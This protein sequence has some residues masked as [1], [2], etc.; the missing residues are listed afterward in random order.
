MQVE[1]QDTYLPAVR[2]KI[3]TF[4]QTPYPVSGQQPAGINT[5]VLAI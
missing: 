5:R 2:L 3:P 4:Y 1:K